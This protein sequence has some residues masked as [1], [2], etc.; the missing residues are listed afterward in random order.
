MKKIK[1]MTNGDRIR[2]FR[3]MYRWMSDNATDEFD[4]YDANDLYFSAN[5]IPTIHNEC[6]LCGTENGC[7]MIKWKVIR[8]CLNSEYDELLTK[9][10]GLTK[11]QRKNRLLKISKLPRAK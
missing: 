2:A 10:N 1:D 3:R 5:K 4:L 9:W 11:H 8:D 7:C 6:Y